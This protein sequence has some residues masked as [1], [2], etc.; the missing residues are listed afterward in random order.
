MESQRP[1][2]PKIRIP[3]LAIPPKP[4]RRPAAAGGMPSLL[5][6]LF[7][8][9][10]LLLVAG[11]AIQLFVLGGPSGRGPGA[12]TAVGAME[13]IR[14]VMLAG[15]AAPR[16]R[17]PAGRFS[18]ALPDG[19]STVEGAE[20]NPF[21]VRLFGPETWELSIKVSE[22]GFDLAGLRALLEKVEYDEGLR[23]HMTD[24]NFLGRPAIARTT[25]VVGQRLIMMDFL[26]DGRAF[27]LLSAAPLAD[28]TNAEP[29][30]VELMKTLEIAPRPAKP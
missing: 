13:S 4:P 27:H 30:L 19:W 2:A 26:D 29:Y 1:E 10:A 15:A 25:R 22:V 11:V 28:S 17:D 9:A 23:T 8:A 12:A 21:E 16:Y 6:M 24:T 14:T 20:A 5:R 18:V 7:P 3:K